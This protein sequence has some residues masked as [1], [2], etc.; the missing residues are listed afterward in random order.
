VDAGVDQR[1]ARDRVQLGVTYFYTRLQRAIAFTGFATDPLGAGRFSGYINRPGGI[2]RGL[3]TSFE[4][5]PFRGNSIRAS[6][7]YTNSDRFAPGRGL[8]PEYVIPKQMLGVNLSQRYRSWSFNFD[9]NRTGSYLSVV[10]ENDFPF[11]Q[12]DMKFRGY[13]KAD[14]F[15]TYER[16]INERVTAVL[17]AGADNLFDRTYFENGFRAAGIAA[18]GGVNF[19]F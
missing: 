19:R 17:F 10:F 1:L 2:A 5:T 15:G 6:Y 9:L 4:L 7:S 12:A 18:R 3:E 13:T 11:R 14:L 16:R 8:V